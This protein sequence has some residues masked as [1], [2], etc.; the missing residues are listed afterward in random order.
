MPP[1]P[2][3][4]RPRSHPLSHV[5][6]YLASGQNAGA[7]DIHLGVNAPPLWR[8][9]GTLQAICLDAPRLTSDHTLALAEGFISK[10]QKAQLNGRGHPSFRYA[11]TSGRKGASLA[12]HSRAGERGTPDVGGR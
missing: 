6:E 1:E 11:E 9:H 8:L 5:D 10:L 7:S 12:R 4:D 2:T 3:Q